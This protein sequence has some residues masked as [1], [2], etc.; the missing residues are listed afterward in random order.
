MTSS[1]SISKLY[2]PLN[3]EKNSELCAEYK[4]LAEAEEKISLVADLASISI[5]IWIR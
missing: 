4:K 5:M 2:Y 1:A 3:D